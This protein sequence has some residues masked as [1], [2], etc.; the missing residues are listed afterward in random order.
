MF[1]RLTFLNLEANEINVSIGQHVLQK[2]TIGFAKRI[3]EK[4]AHFV[5]T[6]QNGTHYFRW[7]AVLTVITNSF[8]KGNIREKYGHGFSIK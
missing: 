4:M 8:S 6:M 2:G 3:T 5:F 1:C 7:T